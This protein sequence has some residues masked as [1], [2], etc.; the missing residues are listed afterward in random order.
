[1]LNHFTIH[2]Y[3]D[4]F[5]FP[6]LVSNTKSLLSISLYAFKLLISPVFVYKAELINVKVN[7]KDPIAM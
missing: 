1:M 4:S 3:P 6:V 5:P 7:H 2:Q